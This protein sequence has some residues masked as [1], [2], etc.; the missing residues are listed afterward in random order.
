MIDAGA[1]SLPARF[2]VAGVLA[3]ATTYDETTA[4]VLA[5][6]RAG[7]G[8]LVAATSVHGVT[9]AA[10]D[11]RF[12]T[13]LNAFDIVPPDGQPVRWGLNLLHGARLADRVYGPTLMLRVCQA[14]A[15]E[16]LGVYFYGSTTAVL[17]RLRAQLAVR[18][19]SVRVAGYHSPPFR[20]STAE[21]DA[22]D[23]QAILDS[24]ARIVFVGLGCPRQEVWAAKNRDRLSLPVL[25]VGAAFDFHAGMLRQAPGWMQRRGLEWAFRLAMEPRRL[26]RR[27][28][29][30]VPMFMFLLSRQYIAERYLHPK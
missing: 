12:K 6:A 18:V 28:L 19:P 3:S 7:R 22:A 13:V 20:P 26:W 29:R 1:R 5:A 16:S 15:H 17:E 2:P 25:C 23:V 30:A 8:L 27:Y 24:G 10:A 11:P 4:H 14:A 21:E 9:I